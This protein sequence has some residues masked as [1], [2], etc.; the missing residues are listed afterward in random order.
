MDTALDSQDRSEL[1]AF[2][3]EL[4]RH[5]ERP[6]EV[7]AVLEILRDCKG[8]GVLETANESGP[9]AGRTTAD[10]RRYDI[11]KLCPDRI[12]RV[13]F[14]RGERNATRMLPHLN[15]LGDAL[16]FLHHFDGT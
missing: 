15:A 1:E 7:D 5:V 4:V 16:Y 11:F 14:V 9:A 6:E 3:E 13:G 2:L 8:G 10:S 12:E